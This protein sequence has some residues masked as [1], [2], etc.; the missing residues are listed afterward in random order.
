MALFVRQDMKK[1]LNVFLGLLLLG[2]TVAQAQNGPYLKIDGTGTPSITALSGK[3]LAIGTQGAQSFRVFTNDS[4]RLTVSSTGQVTFTTDSN[5]QNMSIKS[6]T[7]T[8]DLSDDAGTAT[9]TNLI[10]AGSLVL[11]CTLRV[12]T[13]ITGCTSIKIGDGSD[14]DRWGA[15]IALTSGTT[16]TSANFTGTQPAFFSAANSV[17]L[18]AVGGGADF[19]AGVVRMTCHYISVGAA[20]S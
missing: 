2:A 11:G 17:V 18:T 8:E 10:P 16:T 15:T 4:T 5:G 1:F 12:T 13:T 19:T 7:T 14:D 3:T 20:A 9:L 6:V